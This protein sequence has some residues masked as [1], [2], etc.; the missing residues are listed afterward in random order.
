MSL[1]K[2]F[3]Q[4]EA[5]KPEEIVKGASTSSESWSP[6]PAAEK[7]PFAA[8]KISEETLPQ[9][10]PLA[11]LNKNGNQQLNRNAPPQQE[12]APDPEEQTSSTPATVDKTPG[13]TVAKPVDLSKYMLR[14]E[15]E[16]AIEE[17][18]NKGREEGRLG[19]EHDFIDPTKMLLSAS[20]QIDNIRE[21]LMNNSARELQEFA[22]V[23]AEKILRISLREQDQTL[24]ATIE[25]AL[26][27]AVKSDE[28][29]VYVNPDD[30]DFAVA[31]APSIVTGISGLNH[32]VIKKDTSVERGGA[33]LESDNCTIDAT[34][35]SQLEI[36]REEVKKRL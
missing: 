17:A 11:P 14:V 25:E 21:T 7:K 2:Y 3:K 5:F 6:S 33:K 20:Q 24:I 31:N 29:T 34:V 35:A 18:Y 28:F 30:Y 9:K 23:V 19:V 36:I 4:S 12:K 22:L 15:A 32:L 27:K 16:G 1:S 26:S 13:T 8:Q 10:P